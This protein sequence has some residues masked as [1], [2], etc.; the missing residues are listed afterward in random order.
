[1]PAHAWA[2]DPT[3][4]GSSSGVLALRTILSLAFVLALLLVTLRMLRRLRFADG[5]TTREHPIA[6]RG[7]L[8][9]GARREIRVVDVHGRLLVVGITDQKMELLAELDPATLDAAEV[10]KE[11]AAPAAVAGASA[12]RPAIGRFLQRLITSF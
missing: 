8:D 10:A 5:A 1:M 3:T 6:S 12:T 7:R 2:A 11:S 4:W 9:L